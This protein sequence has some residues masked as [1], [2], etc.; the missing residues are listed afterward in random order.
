MQDN[1]AHYVTKPTDGK[2]HQ[3]DQLTYR[4]NHLENLR[5]KSITP[6]ANHIKLNHNAMNNLL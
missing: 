3:H 1:N 6:S 4:N 2:D 5:I